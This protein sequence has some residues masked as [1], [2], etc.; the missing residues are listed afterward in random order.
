MTNHV[1][2]LNSIINRKGYVYI[3]LNSRDILLVNCDKNYEM[4]DFTDMKIN[5]YDIYPFTFEIIYDREEF[6][7]SNN[8]S[9]LKSIRLKDIQ[10]VI[11]FD[12]VK[13]AY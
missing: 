3:Q 1:E 13:I 9:F 8:G 7:K 10:T 5:E 6:E 2:K 12:R 4:P 11:P